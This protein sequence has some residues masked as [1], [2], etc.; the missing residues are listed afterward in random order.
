MAY[1]LSCNGGEF[2]IHLGVTAQL[3]TPAPTPSHPCVCQ[4]SSGVFANQLSPTYTM[5]L[6]VNYC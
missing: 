6:T 1:A 4:G 2:S 5:D 3:C